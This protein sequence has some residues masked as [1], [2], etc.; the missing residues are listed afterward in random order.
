MTRKQLEQELAEA[1]KRIAE[2]EG[3]ISNA[4]RKLEN[5]PT[6]SILSVDE[7]YDILTPVT[8]LEKGKL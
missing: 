8:E 2:L 6:G 3:Q 7:A 4:L 5:V 1:R